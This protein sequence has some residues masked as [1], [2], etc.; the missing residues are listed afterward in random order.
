MA[1]TDYLPVLILNEN[2]SLE[3]LSNR[4]IYSIHLHVTF[5]T[6]CLILNKITSK[7]HLIAQ[8]YTT[9]ILLTKKIKLNT[10]K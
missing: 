1:Q 2:I 6:Y 9:T 3:L 8:S 7:S 5:N 4:H 10:I